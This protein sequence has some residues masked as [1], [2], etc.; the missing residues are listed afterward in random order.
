MKK[1]KKALNI[2]GMLKGI[3]KLCVIVLLDFIE[4]KTVWELEI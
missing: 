3:V 4:V 1:K 2:C